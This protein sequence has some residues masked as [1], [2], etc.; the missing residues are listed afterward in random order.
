MPNYRPCVDTL[1]RQWLGISIGLLALFIALGGPA[2]ASDTARAVVKQITGKQIKDGSIGTKDL[3]KAARTSLKGQ[4]GPGPGPARCHRRPGSAR[5]AGCRGTSRRKAPRACR[6]TRRRSTACRPAVTSPAPTRTRPVLPGA[7]AAT[8]LGV[9]PAVRIVGSAAV[10]PDTTVTTVN[11]GSGQQFETVATMYDPTEGTKLVAP[12][13][14]LYLAHASLGFN[15]NANG[16][17]TVAIAINGS[18]SNPACFDRQDSASATLATFVNATCVVQAERRGVR[19]RDRH[20]D[21][22]RQSGLQRLRKRVA[23]VARQAHAGHV[24]RGQSLARGCAVAKTSRRLS[25]VTRV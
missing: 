17:R 8:E 4:Q 9:V 19:H 12:V 11:W 15:A 7:V 22:G 1:K 6:V 20:A 21:L 2:A 24:T 25:T 18:N 3:S 5:R 13:T 14:G 23:H 16:V 10:I